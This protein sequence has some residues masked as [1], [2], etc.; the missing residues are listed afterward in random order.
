MA[1]Y[2]KVVDG[3]VVDSIVDESEFFKTFV[4]SSPGA[5]IE[6]FKDANG[7]PEKRYNYVGVGGKYDAKA[8][9]FIM[10]CDFESW[11]LNTKT[12]K[13]EPP[14]AYPANGKPHFWDEDKKT[15]VEIT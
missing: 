11:T 8:D 9:A 2:C 1:I 15:W 10:P 4:D 12:Y 7:E 6:A 3:T 14:V 13:Y 5:W